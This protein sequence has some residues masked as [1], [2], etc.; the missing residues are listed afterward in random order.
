MVLSHQLQRKKTIRDHTIILTN[1]PLRVCCEMFRR[2]KNKKKIK[3]IFIYYIE[4]HN[5]NTVETF[6]AS[7]NYSNYFKIYLSRY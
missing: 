7:A 1:E 5:P 3:N 2:K 6:G 4:V